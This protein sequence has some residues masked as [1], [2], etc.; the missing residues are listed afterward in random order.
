[1]VSILLYSAF[2]LTLLATGISFS[3]KD[4]TEKLKYQCTLWNLVT[5][6]LWMYIALK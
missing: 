1:M 4:G 3:M 5:V 6:F 2:A